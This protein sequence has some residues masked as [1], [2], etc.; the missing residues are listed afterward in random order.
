MLPFTKGLVDFQE[1]RK[2]KDQEKD[3]GM[4]S[5]PAFLLQL[6]ERLVGDNRGS[7]L[8]E[9]HAP[10]GVAEAVDIKT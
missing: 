1:K 7:V 10:P 4:F 5:R 9:A 3:A 8:M 6:T 2:E